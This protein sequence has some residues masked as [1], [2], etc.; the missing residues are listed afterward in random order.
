MKTMMWLCPQ[1][2]KISVAV[3]IVEPTVI[4]PLQPG[5]QAKE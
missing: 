1:S 2:G 5:N 4:Y 3:G